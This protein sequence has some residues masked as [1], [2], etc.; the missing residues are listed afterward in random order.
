MAA[1]VEI[2]PGAGRQNYCVSVVPIEFNH[3]LQESPSEVLETTGQSGYHPTHIERH[4][5]RPF[6]GVG[7]YR[8]KLIIISPSNRRGIVKRLDNLT[9]SQAQAVPEFRIA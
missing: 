8:T 4:S 2:I 7:D 1:K 6:V 3:L 5:H 9:T